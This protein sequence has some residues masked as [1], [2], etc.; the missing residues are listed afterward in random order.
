VEVGDGEGDRSRS[1]VFSP[2]IVFVFAQSVLARVV[3]AVLLFVIAAIPCDYEHPD[4]SH[5]VH[6]RQ[7]DCFFVIPVDWQFPQG[8]YVFHRLTRC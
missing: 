4:T 3:A 6:I 1:F 5:V 7:R 8:G 2:F